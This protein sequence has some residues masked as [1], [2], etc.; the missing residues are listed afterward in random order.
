MGISRG[1][2]VGWV[3]WPAFGKRGE[4]TEKWGKIGRRV[5][6]ERGR[7]LDDKSCCDSV[8]GA[9]SKEKEPVGGVLISVRATQSTLR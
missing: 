9:R 7:R 4:K 3:G 1:G 2:H 6:N 8:G 5:G